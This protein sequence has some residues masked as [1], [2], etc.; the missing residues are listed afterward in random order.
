MERVPQ[1]VQLHPRL[2]LIQLV[3]RS[4]HAGVLSSDQFQ[5]IS[6]T[7]DTV[8]K[9]MGCPL[10]FHTLLETRRATFSA[11]EY[12][13]RAPNDVPLHIYDV[14]ILPCQ[15]V[16]SSLQTLAIWKDHSLLAWM[17]IRL[18]RTL[19]LLKALNQFFDRTLTGWRST[20]E[21]LICK[22]LQDTLF[23]LQSIQDFI[24]LLPAPQT[25]QEVPFERMPQ[26]GTPPLHTWG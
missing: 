10:S 12:H 2:L 15:D 13:L 6:H 14:A 18:P 19:D 5:F 20:V 25:P 7:I 11:F 9:I 4:I 1:P 17:K 8:M 3:V 23:Q 22:T 16:S 24:A 21:T 26:P